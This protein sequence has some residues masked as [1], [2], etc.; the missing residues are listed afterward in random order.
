V[1]ADFPAVVGPFA[2]P[3][4][5]GPFEAV[6]APP[7]LL[8]A[9]AAGALAGAAAGLAAG[10]AGAAGFFSWALS[11]EEPN[12]ATAR[13]PAKCRCA[14]MKFS[15]KLLNVRDFAVHKSHFA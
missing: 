2:A 14:F 11:I 1:G 6:L 8:A 13:M 12:K 7:G 9:L 15:F 10:L 4:V 5:V 3:A